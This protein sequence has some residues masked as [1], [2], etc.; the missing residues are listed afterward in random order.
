MKRKLSLSQHIIQF[1]RFLR[2]HEYPLS[3]SEEVDAL[4]ALGTIPWHDGKYFKQSL[5]AVLV[6]NVQQLRRFD[7]LYTQY[8]AE[9]SRAEDSKLRDGEPEKRKAPPQKKAPPIR[10]I[11][12][13]LH[14]NKQIEEEEIATYS[15]GESFVEK[16]FGSFAKEELSEVMRV[17]RALAKKLA[18]QKSCRYENSK[19][20][21]QL[22]LR[23]LMR[24]NMRSGGEFLELTYK[25]PKQRKIKIILLCDVSKSMDLYSRF[26]I[27]F[28]YGFQNSY[29]QIETFVFS[30]RLQ[31]ITQQ[32]KNQEFN[33][34][35]KRLSAEVHQWSSGTKIGASL[36]TF[37]HDYGSRLVNQKSVVIILSDGWDTGDVD[38]LEDSMRRIH[39]KAGKVLWLNPLAGN[40]NY[41]PSTQGMKAAMPYIDVF[42]PV[43]NVD[44]LRKIAS[45]LRF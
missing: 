35:L 31:R 8:W 15:T 45:Q 17:I 44:S 20:N 27:Q 16:D 30:T 37:L 36:Q 29:R 14:G 38:I 19:K 25:K 9:L 1:C 5:R 40:P 33:S 12:N 13:W 43:H 41:K 23:R 39:R 18:N 28:M 34:A 32:L 6:K 42:A 10:V 22:D 11:K 7:D 26:L 4:N 24:K 21:E 2:Q 3:P